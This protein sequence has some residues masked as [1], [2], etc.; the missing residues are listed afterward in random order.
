MERTVRISPESSRPYVRASNGV[1]HVID[2]VILPVPGLPTITKLTQSTKRLM[3]LVASLT[4][5]GLV[6]TTTD[7]NSELTVF[8]PIEKAFEKFGKDNLDYLFNNP[9]IWKLILLNHITKGTITSEMLI[10][11]LIEMDSIET[12]LD[13][14]LGVTQKQE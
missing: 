8:T 1:I 5:T 4:C 12:L 11:M 10:K 6:T 9:E 14:S 2:E 3:T 7:Q 13:Q